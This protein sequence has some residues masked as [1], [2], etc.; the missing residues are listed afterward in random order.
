[1]KWDEFSPSRHAVELTQ[2]ENSI[3]H[4]PTVTGEGAGNG[5]ACV[6]SP[7]LFLLLL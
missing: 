3:L 4:P 5:Q 1:M 2:W 6:L 7:C